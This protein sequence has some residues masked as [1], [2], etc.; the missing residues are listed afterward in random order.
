MYLK[1]IKAVGFKSF[2]DKTVIE[3]NKDITAVV[4]PNGSGKSN[5]VDAIRWVLGEQSVKQLRGSTIMSDVIFSGSAAREPLKK[6]SVT[7]TFDNTD[8]YLKSE[9]TEIEIKREVYKTGEND[10]FINNARV[11]LKDIKDLFLD[12][13]AGVGAFNIISQGNI[14]DIVNSKAVDRRIIFESAAGVLKYKTRKEEAIK[15][16]EK[17]KDNLTSVKL[18]VEELDKTIKPLKKQSEAAKEYLEYKKDLENLEIALLA[19]DI[20]N[21]NNEI[22]EITEQLN[23]L[24]KS[25][26]N[27]SLDKTISEIEVL[28]LESIKLED[29]INKVNQNIILTNEE[30][31][32]LSSEKQIT[33]ER[34][35]FN[36]KNVSVNDAL[37]KL[38]EEESDLLKRENVLVKELEKLMSEKNDLTKKIDETSNNLISLRIKKSNLYG[39]VENLEKSSIYLKNKIEIT[40]NNILNK[41]FYPKSVRAVLTNASLKGIVDTIGNLINV[42][43]EYNKAYNASMGNAINNIV[44]DNFDSAKNAI[45]YLKNNK[46]GKV[47]FFPLDIIK[48]RYI[49]KDNLDVLKE[50]SN[51]IGVFSDLVKFDKKYKNIIENLL[52]NVLVVKNLDALNKIGKKID[53]KYKIVSL[54]GSILFAGGSVTGGHNTD[55]KSSK[56]LLNELEN[57]LSINI[58]N[59]N[60]TN[61]EYKNI[62]EEY[63]K[64]D[65][66]L[67][68][69]NKKNIL[70]NESISSKNSNIKELTYKLENKTLEIKGIN[71]V[72]GNKLEEELIYLIEAL[73]EKAKNKISF[74]EDLKTFKDRKSD[75]FDT[76]ATL[77]NSNKIKQVEINKANSYIKSKEV[78]LAKLEIKIENL[79]LN[80]TE[81]YKITHEYAKENYFLD[82]SVADA[83]D[84]TNSLKRSM[85]ALGT[86]NL[87]SIEQYDTLSERYNFLKNQEDDLM[88][89]SDN[90][91]NII[92]E[93][94]DIMVSKFKESFDLVSKEFEVVFKKIFQGGKGKLSLTDPNDLLN[95]GI[96]IMAEPPGKRLNST[97]ALSGGE[98]S[99]T[100]ICLLFSILNVRP[101]PF[102]IL[103]EAEAALDEANVDM[104]GKYIN[105]MK[106]ESQFILITHKKRMMEYADLLYGITMQE[107]GVSKIVS[108]KLEN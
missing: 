27:I 82:S 39:S 54:D 46:L 77:E 75:I 83:R 3:F 65:E 94:D 45:E 24:N 19:H 89:A 87:G 59:I 32:K 1:S 68:L 55:D 71:N 64:C 57:E 34:Q 37:L 8:H 11:R 81:N 13:G 35:R 100:A 69:L 2:A 29:E 95:T 56:S 106:K 58:K 48:S 53:Y 84:K 38:K 85:N 16:L 21:Y 61:I 92:N 51:Y 50:E 99:L 12:S 101:V 88:E 79:L 41:D 31:S 49:K 40:K 7:L 42:D 107:S 105:D 66:M 22:E 78:E 90:L 76:I 98:K 67:D 17:T 102:I 104:F 18:V 96:E 72:A 47:T 10:Y 74:E 44:T 28:K 9:F 30:I 36:S 20:T 33:I 62:S 97:V 4:G 86:I 80:L 52:G 6:A 93:M 60:K 43:D 63:F 15:K 70:L 25:I 23:E 103:D 5:V 73:T 108:T 91:M 14:T 26:S